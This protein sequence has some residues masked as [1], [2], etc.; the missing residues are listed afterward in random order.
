MVTVDVDPVTH[1]LL[2]LGRVV[3]VTVSCAL[4]VLT[5]VALSRGLRLGEVRAAA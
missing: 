2:H 4:G 1:A 3:F 5:G